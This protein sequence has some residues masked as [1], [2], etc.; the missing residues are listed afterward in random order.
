MA[1]VSADYT[2]VATFC[3]NA[4]A[5]GG[6]ISGAQLV[7]VID[8]I[9]HAANTLDSKAV[10]TSVATEA[11]TTAAA[12]AVGTV[13]TDAD[14]LEAE[15]VTQ[16]AAWN[17][18]G[19]GDSSAVYTAAL[20]ALAPLRTAL[21]ASADAAVTAAAAADTAAVAGVTAGAAGITNVTADDLTDGRPAQ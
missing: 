18:V 4:L 9:Q 7:K 6:N 11:A 19:V 2:T 20:A 16:M 8:V 1:V 15:L 21:I 13:N 10:A 5:V 12:T 17:A 14:A 3:R